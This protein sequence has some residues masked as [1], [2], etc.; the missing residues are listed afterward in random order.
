MKLDPAGE[1]LARMGQALERTHIDYYTGHCTGLE[2]YARLTQ[3]M[4]ERLHYL[5][6]GDTIEL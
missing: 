2:Q 3:I 4:G 5:A 1:E 6:A